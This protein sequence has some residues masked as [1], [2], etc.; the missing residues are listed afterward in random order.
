MNT[1]ILRTRAGGVLW[2][3]RLFHGAFGAVLPVLLGVCAASWRYNSAAA[4]GAAAVLGAGLWLAHRLLGP[5]LDA[6]PRRRF[7]VLFAACAAVYLAVLTA[8]GLALTEVLISDMGVVYGTLGEFL[9]AGHPVQNNDYYIICS[10]NLGLALLLAA[11]Y[12]VTGIEPDQTTGV[13]AGICLNC[14]AIFV[15]VLLVCAAVRL[16]TGRQSAQLLALGCCAAFAPFYLWA[17]YFY[18][19]T[20]CMPFLMG[21]VVLF[22]LYRRGAG[23]GRLWLAALC[24]AVS[25]AG[26]AVKGSLAVLP[27]AAV[28]AL[29]AERRDWRAALAAAAAFAVLL[30]GYHLFEQRYLDWSRQEQI[31]FPTELWL[32]YGS[33]ELG[34]YNQAD[35]DLCQSLPTL[36][37]R[38]QALREQLARNYRS[39]TAAQ[40]VD[41][42]LRKA[43]ATW[44]DGEYGAREYL[45]APLRTSF[46]HRFTLEGQPGY[47]PLG[48][49]CQAWQ[50][51]LLALTA[52]GSLWAARRSDGALMPRVAL[53]GVMLFLSLWETK[54]RYALHFAPV[55]LLCAVLALDRLVRAGTAA[56]R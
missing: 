1:T 16:L 13:A 43:A 44:G 30:A 8:V 33:H 9:A 11:F 54:A 27:V 31:G 28:I 6:L 17:P 47:M 39:R 26:F 29:L 18:S 37:A 35:A 46:L 24:G 12:A 34:D 22:L 49:Y 19:D 48:Y 5:G 42:E 20:L 52:L 21:A 53:F 15:S 38:R 2:A 3:E 56:R 23:R 25:M 32:C 36:T 45:A 51:L 4:L 55:L 40:T 50:Y 7:A 14:G 10:N 41:F